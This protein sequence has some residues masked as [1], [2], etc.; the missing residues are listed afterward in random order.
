MTGVQTCALPISR[1][2][3]ADEP[4]SAVDVSL[5]KQ[6]LACFKSLREHL[7]IA[8][9]LIT[10]DLRIVSEIADRVIVMRHGHI[11]ESVAIADFFDGRRAPYTQALIDAI[12]GR[13]IG[14]QRE[15][16]PA[17]TT[18]LRRAERDAVGAGA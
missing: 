6:I 4:L 15:E 10:H 12:P 14:Q 9:L 16:T 1:L 13:F 8:I 5:Q 18:L 17:A 3:I 7:G 2:L 11:L